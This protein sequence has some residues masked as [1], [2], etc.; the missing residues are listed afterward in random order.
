MKNVLVINTSLN[1]EQGNSNKL[2][3]LFM[4]HWQQ[5]ESIELTKRNLNTLDLPHLSGE[6]MQA[7][8][9]AVDDRSPQQHE[10]AAY[11]D[12]LIAELKAADSIV[13]GMPMYNFG[14][15]STFKAWIDRVARAGIT[16]SYTEQGPKGLLEG[17]KVTILAVR[18]GI[19]AG[20][21]KDS[22]SQYLKDV[23][24]FLGMTDV[25]FIYAEGLAM[26]E[27]SAAKAW[28]A[29]EQRMHEILS[30]LAA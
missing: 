24:A 5:A 17:K 25:E 2:T 23:L 30:P 27:E 6:E 21:P 7:W 8:E 10:L 12:E 11:S 15:P 14:V 16:F 26:G 4:Q 28:S 19:Y 20:T 18:G 29:A 1:N 22:Q 3:E 13:L 9:T